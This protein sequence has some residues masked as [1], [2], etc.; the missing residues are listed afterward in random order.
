MESRVRQARI[1]IFSAII[2]RAES[3]ETGVR[4]PRLQREEE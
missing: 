4:R 1:V 2:A 3:D